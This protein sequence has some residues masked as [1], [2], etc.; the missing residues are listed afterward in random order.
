[1]SADRVVVV[2]LTCDGCGEELEGPV[3]MVDAAG[4]KIE[5]NTIPA[6]RQKART[7]GWIKKRRDEDYCDVCVGD[8]T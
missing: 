5:R 6:L 8:G 4:R 2:S 7:L 1:M 3:Q